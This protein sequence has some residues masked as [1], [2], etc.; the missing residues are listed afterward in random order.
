MITR[1]PIKNSAEPLTYTGAFNDEVNTALTAQ[2]IFTPGQNA[3]GAYIELISVMLDTG[4]SQ[5]AKTE[6][7]L[8]AKSSAPNNGTD[9]DVVF[10]ATSGTTMSGTVTANSIPVNAH[11][12]GRIKI[13]AGKGLYLNQAVGTNPAA[14]AKKSVLYTLL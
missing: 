1:S 8:I 10:Q 13:A 6:V 12:V 2:V 3:N 4:T 9:G 7:K 5:Y 11:V 14:S